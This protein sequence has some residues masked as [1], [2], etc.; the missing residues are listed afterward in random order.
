MEQADQRRLG[1]RTQVDEILNTRGS[2]IGMI[3]VTIDLRIIYS[4]S[5]QY[6]RVQYI[7]NTKVVA[8]RE[9]SGIV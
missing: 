4:L 8:K 6:V 1:T 5:Q 9:P 3:K 7:G 2:T